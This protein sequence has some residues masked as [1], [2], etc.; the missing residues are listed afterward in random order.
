MCSEQKRF[1]NLDQFCLIVKSYLSH[2][3]KL[4]DILDDMRLHGMIFDITIVKEIHHPMYAAEFF[5]RILLQSYG[6][7]ITTPRIVF[8]VDPEF[9]VSYIH[10]NP[11]QGADYE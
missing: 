7:I 11:L 6:K 2:K 8:T 5:C 1:Y 3:T 4:V 9:S 10:I